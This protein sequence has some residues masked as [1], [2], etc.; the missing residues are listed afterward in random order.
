MK[1]L[2]TGSTGYLGS[3]LAQRLTK[4]NHTLGCVVRCPER[5]GRLEP[6]REQVRLLPVDQLGDEMASFRPKIII[7]MPVPISAVITRRGMYW[8]EICFSPSCDAS[9]QRCGYKSG[10]QY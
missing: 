4:K 1:I 7:H 8:K 9:S 2:L 10:D 6:L 3:H 5:L